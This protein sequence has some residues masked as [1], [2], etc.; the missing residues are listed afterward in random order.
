M[1]CC[2]TC[3]IAL[4]EPAGAAKQ[5][6]EKEAAG[7]RPLFEALFVFVFLEGGGRARPR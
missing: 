6:Q 4:A 5:K 3:L 7:R 1:R 2:L